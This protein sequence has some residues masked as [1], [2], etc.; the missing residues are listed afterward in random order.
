MTEVPKHSTT[1]Q[2]LRDGYSFML[3]AFKLLVFQQNQKKNAMLSNDNAKKQ[4]AVIK[5]YY[6]VSGALFLLVLQQIK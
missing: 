4:Q 2:T 1:F 6:F 3:L 5:W